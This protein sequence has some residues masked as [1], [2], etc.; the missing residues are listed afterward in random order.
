MPEGKIARAGSSQLSTVQQVAGPRQ[1]SKED[2]LHQTL[3][4]LEAERRSLLRQLLLEVNEPLPQTS[5]NPNYLPSV[6]A[7]T[8][9]LT[10]LTPQVET[11]LLN[12]AQSTIKDHIKLLHQYN[13]TRDIGL[14][15]IGMIAESRKV[16]I[17]D[18]QEE[19]GVGEGD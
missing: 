14:G 12:N 2:E 5:L 11:E 9:P 13:E 15:L 3:L 18:C 1:V 7:H 10:L 19:Y 6:H 4:Q 17:R 8:R 16:R